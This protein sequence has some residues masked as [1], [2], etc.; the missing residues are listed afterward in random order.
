MTDKETETDSKTYD[1]RSKYDGVP[2]FMTVALTLSQCFLL[3]LPIAAI[4]FMTPAEFAILQQ[5]SPSE[6]F[7]NVWLTL[8]GFWVGKQVYDKK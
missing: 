7:N 5:I 4:H 8:V 2:A 3:L 1:P 6:T